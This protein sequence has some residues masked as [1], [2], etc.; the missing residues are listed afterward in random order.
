MA[1]VRR[2][3]CVV[4]RFSKRVGLVPLAL[5]VGALF[6]FTGG[7]LA[8]PSSVRVRLSVHGGV[9]TLKVR[10]NS[11]SGAKCSLR[12]A[13]GHR[14]ATFTVWKVAASGSTLFEWDVPSDAPSGKWSFSGTCAKDHH[15][16]SARRTVRLIH[17]GSGDGPLVSAFNG[18]GGKGGGNQSCQPIEQ[19]GSG[20]VCFIGDPFAGYADPYVGADI[21]QCTWYAAGMRPDLDGITTGNAGDWLKEAAGK[22]PEG[23]VPTIGAIAVNDTADG[24]VGH[25]AYVAGV[26]NGG[27]TLILDEANLHYNG[28]VFLNVSTPAADFQGYIY[29]GSAGNGPGSPSTTPTTPTLPTGTYA[30][31]AGS[32]ANTW[33]DYQT[34]GGT[35]GPQIAGGQT[36]GITCRVQGYGVPDG[37]TWW[38]QIGSSPWDDNYYVTADAFYNNGQTSG[39]LNNTPFVD[40]KVAICPPPSPPPTTTTTTPTPPPP[41][42]PPTW[43]ETVGPGGANTWTDYA[44]AGGTEGSHIPQYDTVQIT[45]RLQGFTVADGNTW[46]YRIASSP[47][48]NNYY[49]SA[50]AFYNNG[51]TSGSLHGT[52]FFDPNVAMC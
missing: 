12:V 28:G 34:A 1:E 2:N 43:S 46:W 45:C 40:Q 47:W 37:N 36:V 20:Q 48:D 23:T 26:T 5:L 4:G 27:A 42:P 17:H 44:N 3:G 25:V 52:P 16:G 13:A 33:S 9:H 30:E 21:G 41:S 6:F 38:Y 22:R 39:G 29:G 51:Q 14:A 15:R 19:G 10:L 8:R 18:G 49:V 24:G 32:V 31:T 50:D 11:V 7:A 35:E